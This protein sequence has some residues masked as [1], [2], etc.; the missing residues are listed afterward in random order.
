MKRMNIMTGRSVRLGAVL[1]G[2][3]SLSLLLGWGLTRG[4]SRVIQTI[5]G[6][7]ETGFMG[8][9]GPAIEA[10]LNTMQGLAIDAAGNLY[11]AEVSNHVVRRVDPSGVIS[12]VA[13]LG[14]DQAGFNGDNQPATQ[15]KLAAPADV[16]IDAGGN[17]YIADNGNHRIRRVDSNGVITTVVGTGVSGFSGDGGPATAARL[18]NPAAIA[19]DAAGNLYIGEAGNLRI[20][21]VD[22]ATGIITTIAGTGAYGFS[23]DGGLATTARF[24][25]VS[26][27]AIG[28]AGDIFVADSFNNRVRRISPDGII[29]TVAGRGDFNV[30]VAADLGDGGAATEA[31]VRTPFGLAFDSAGNLYI[32]ENSSHRIRRV[33]G[34]GII[35]TVAGSGSP[36]EPGSGGDGGPADQ[37]KLN[38]PSGVL[39]D[40]A[41]NI[42]ISDSFNFRVR[43]VNAQ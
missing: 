40:A 21:R 4:D 15:A 9:G 7:G 32:A 17:L 5:A 26:D 37:A 19:L 23:G 8:D 42:Y 3:L 38:R 43:R 22:R 10:K 28:P 39:V 1:I 30:S 31:I 14:P 25:N 41:G 13:G 35:T 36:L 27:L 20:R 33:D 6:N 16:A 24:K 2:I 11:I 12:T 29:T 18:R 34:S